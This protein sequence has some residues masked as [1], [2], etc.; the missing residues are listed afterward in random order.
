MAEYEKPLVED[1][2]TSNFETEND[3]YVEGKWQPRTYEILT[4]DDEEYYLNET[5]SNIKWGL[6]IFCGCD[7]HE[8][9][10]DMVK[11]WGEV[12]VINLEIPSLTKVEYN[13][14][15]INCPTLIS[16]LILNRT[17]NQT[18]ATIAPK[19]QNIINEAK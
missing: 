13:T 4:V 16:P 3:V 6:Q 2:Y 14:N 12:I 19:R 5:D 18:T 8:Y 15:E 17:P 9:I 1:K 11:D 7:N 10:M